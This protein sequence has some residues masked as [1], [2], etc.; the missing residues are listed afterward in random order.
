MLLLHLVG[1][2][3]ITITRLQ[4]NYPLG[5][6]FPNGMLNPNLFLRMMSKLLRNSGMILSFLIISSVALAQ[7]LSTASD[8]GEWKTDADDL[9]YFELN[10]HRQECPWYQFSHFQGTGYNPVLTNQWGDV[11]VLSTEHGLTNLT[12]S[13]WYS[14]GGFYPMIT[15]RGELVSLIISELDTNKLVN[16][17]VGYTEY[18]GEVRRDSI[19]LKISYR[20]ITP[21]DDSSGFYAQLS[22][23]NLSPDPLEGELSANS[24][25]WIRPT[26]GSVEAWREKVKTLDNTLEKGQAVVRGIDKHFRNIALLG[27]SSYQGSLATTTLR[28]SKS[29]T[30]PPGQTE[31]AQFR[32]CY[33]QEPEKAATPLVSFTVDSLA[34]TWNK[35]LTPLRDSAYPSWINR[36]MVWT[37]AQL[38]SMCFYDQSLQEHFVHLG[39]YGIGTDPATPGTGGFTMREVAETAIVLAEHTPE[40]TRS[41]L[42][43]MAKTQLVGG[44]LRRAHLHVPLERAAPDQQRD[45]HFPDES[46][47]EIWFL[48]AAGEYFKTTGDT[49]FFRQRVPFRTLEASGT[50]W[51]HLVAAYR[52]IRHDVG[53]G[54]HGLIK[55]LNGDWN[56]YLSRIG[57]EGHGE[58]L[59]NTG[60]MCRALINMHELALVFN[61]PVASELETYLRELQAA[62]TASFDQEWFIR[63][64]DDDGQP[65]GGADD[66]LFLNAQSWAA[67]GKCGT[68]QQRKKSLLNAVK[69]CSTPI[70]MTLVSRPYS[71]PTPDHVSWA[72]IPAGEGENAGIWPQTGAWII[73]ALAEEGLTEVART[74]WEKNTLTNHTKRY[75][76]VPFGIINGPDCYS[77]HYA[78]EREGW[79]QVEMFNRMIPIPMNPIIAWQSFGMGK[80]A[81]YRE[82]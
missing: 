49:S 12:P 41:S 77:S 66:R 65:V 80:I 48:I 31:T 42:R 19:H 10:F 37:Y 29:L 7:D 78:H 3:P 59:M 70:G 55:M 28:L 8:F 30:L 54:D 26:Y 16:Y 74:E 82:P 52:F 71:S 51:E 13:L 4:C 6:A 68:E 33:N 76:G 32:F 46:D 47:T 56:D 11:N 25:I 20:I 22:L 17:G 34:R 57:S 67:L 44:D 79:T 15:V 61:D 5:A 64:Y 53:T 1:G 36:E 72:P 9:P 23:T 43:W 50:V 63:A 38:L 40:L 60:M 21:F 45:E 14:R 69:K 62:V 39:G 35:V 18:S 24:D 2:T 73:W 75:P 58:S 27:D 81:A